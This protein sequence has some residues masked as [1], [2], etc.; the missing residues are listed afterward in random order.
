MKALWR[1]LAMVIL[2]IYLLVSFVRLPSYAGEDVCKKMNISILDG[3][4][5]QYF[6]AEDIMT[7]LDDCTGES[8]SA[9]DL[10]QMEQR[11]LEGGNLAS[12]EC[13]KLINGVVRVEVTQ[14]RPVM[15]VLDNEGGFFVDPD[16]NCLS[17]CPQ[18]Q[19]DLPLVTGHVDSVLT[20][21][22]ILPLAQYIGQ[23]SFW[24]AQIEQIYVNG[25]H[26]IELTP[27]VGSQVVLLGS[28]E[29]YETKLENLMQVYTQVF[30]HRDGI[31]YDTISLKYQ[32]QVVCSCK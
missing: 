23:D 8:M 11:L 1:F 3:A 27:R 25:R 12:A 4:A 30:K 26:E 18:Y 9:I 31:A 21:K 24:N 19:L 13:Y 16:G 17:V 28:L 5:V 22:E 20:Y 2:L 15:R 14:R 29:D 6:T 32:G 10:A 7:Y